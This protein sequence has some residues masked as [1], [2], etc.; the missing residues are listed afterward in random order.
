MIRILS[1]LSLLLALPTAGAATDVPPAGYRW[2][3]SEAA[4][5]S[6]LVPDG[7]FV[8]EEAADG[9]AALFVT[10]EDIAATGEFRTGLTLNTISGVK[11]RTGAPASR[12]AV[13][14]LTEALKGNDELTS[15][16]QEGDGSV[17]IGLRVRNDRIGRIVHYFVVASDRSDTMHLFFFEAPT[18][19]WDA[20]WAVG[21][22][23]FRNLRVVY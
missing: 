8:K 10:K 22:P 19:E 14:F 5:A 17:A 11:R 16:V 2:Q 9:T 13:A 23:I 21:E 1:A 3:V 12:Y 4:A 18:E 7:W 15:F 20:A 6:V